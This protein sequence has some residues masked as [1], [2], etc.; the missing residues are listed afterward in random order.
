MCAL[1][2]FYVQPVRVNPQSVIMT[3]SVFLL[4]IEQLL[5]GFFAGIAGYVKKKRTKRRQ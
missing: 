5:V 1:A 3:R 4:Y 2:F